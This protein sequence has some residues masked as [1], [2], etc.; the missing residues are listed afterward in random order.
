MRR[1]E[2]WVANLNPRRGAEVG[3]VRPILVL[4]ADRLIDSP[5]EIGRHLVFPS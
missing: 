2:V 1:G 5:A 3:K 4:E